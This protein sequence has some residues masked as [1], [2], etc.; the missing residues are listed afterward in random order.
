MALIEQ[1]NLGSS[2]KDCNRRLE[3][4]SMLLEK[5]RSLKLDGS[6]HLIPEEHFNLSTLKW[7]R[8]HYVSRRYP[9][10]LSFVDVDTHKE[11]SEPIFTGQEADLESQG[12]LVPLL[13]ILNHN[14]DHPWLTFRVEGGYLKVICNHPVRKVYYPDVASHYFYFT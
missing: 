14:H 5:M 6:S 7:A 13:D 8:G 4:Q 2:L 9:A 11:V 1:S 3:Q 12:C 10:R